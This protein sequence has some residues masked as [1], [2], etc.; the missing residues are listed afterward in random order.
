MKSNA[1]FLS[2]ATLSISFL[3]ATAAPAA[4]L[5]S[6]TDAPSQSDTFFALPFL[7]TDKT[8]TIS[9]SGYQPP[10]WEYATDIS[11]TLSG[12]T[13]NLLGSSWFFLPAAQGSYAMTIDDG[14][15]VPGLQFGGL[16][17]GN[18]DTFSQFVPTQAGDSYVLSFFYSNNL[19]GGPNANSPSGFLVVQIAG[20]PPNLGSVSTGS[21]SW[22]ADAG[23]P[24][25]SSWALMLLG[26]AGLGLAGYW[27]QRGNAGSPSL[28]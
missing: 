7:A 24:E 3:L 9:I 13:T 22:V 17:P 5:L 14:S 21:V 18:Y 6:L 19:Y 8:T 20:D 2:L 1:F 28:S 25:P 16:T 26:F 27:R 12:S 11:V 23:V 15:S 4:T 10:S